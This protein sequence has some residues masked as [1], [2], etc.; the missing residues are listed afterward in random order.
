MKNVSERQLKTCIFLTQ[1]ELENILTEIEGKAITVNVSLYG[2]EPC[3]EGNQTDYDNEYLNSVLSEYFDV[4]V[5]SVHC[6]DCEMT[7]IWICYKDT[8][9]GVNDENAS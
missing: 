6:D 2:L 5:T 3:D 9:A 4:E 8:D 1:S 7:G